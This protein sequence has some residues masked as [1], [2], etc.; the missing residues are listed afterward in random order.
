MLFKNLSEE[1]ESAQTKKTTP[2]GFANGV[3]LTDT[4]SAMPAAM[5][6]RNSVASES[7]NDE[8]GASPDMQRGHDEF[9]HGQSS[10]PG[11]THFV[12]P[13]QGVTRKR[14]I[15]VF[16]DRGPSSLVTS[17]S[18]AFTQ[19]IQRSSTELIS[20][21]NEVEFLSSPFSER[22]D[23]IIADE[24]GLPRGEERERLIDHVCAS[25]TMPIFIGNPGS[26]FAKR[27]PPAQ[28]RRFPKTHAEVDDVVFQMFFGPP[29]VA[30]LTLHL[31][32]VLAWLPDITSPI[33]VADYLEFLHPEQYADALQSL[34]GCNNPRSILRWKL[35]E[36]LGDLLFGEERFN[37]EADLLPL[38]D[39][40][41]FT[42]VK[43]VAQQ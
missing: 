40:L 25:P 38:G 35:L 24:L 23:L 20:I 10:A 12:C 33:E 36:V 5:P 2:N 4:T 41:N 26:K 30:A 13:H 15:A 42:L 17:A 3:Y 1:R 21:P 7:T 6:D 22:L 34:R 8:V 32:D 19:G 43:T 16:G 9:R 14:R 29:P 28:V 31:Y 18:I 37:V 11:N 39:H 27:L